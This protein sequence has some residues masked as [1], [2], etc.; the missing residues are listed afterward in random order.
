[1]TD[2]DR[3]KEKAEIAA[4]ADREVAI[5]VSRVFTRNRLFRA[6]VGHLAQEITFQATGKVHHDGPGEIAIVVDLNYNMARGTMPLGWL[7]LK[8]APFRTIA[9][10]RVVRI[11]PRG[12][13]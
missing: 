1:M 11:F 12:K 3:I 4:R 2:L 5:E 8:H 9:L 13:E 10:H 7:L 6:T